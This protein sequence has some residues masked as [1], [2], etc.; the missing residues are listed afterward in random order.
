MG[1]NCACSSP[2]N[3]VEIPQKSDASKPDKPHPLRIPEKKRLP[4]PKKNSSSSV[5][6]K[7]SE[8]S[9]GNDKCHDSAHFNQFDLEMSQNSKSLS[10]TGS[11]Q[12]Q[13]RISEERTVEDR[14]SEKR[15]SDLEPAAEISQEQSVTETLEKEISPTETQEV[16]VPTQA[17]DEPIVKL[18]QFPEPISKV[19]KTMILENAESFLENVE[20]EEI[21]NQDANV[22]E[23]HMEME[24]EP[25]AREKREI[26][27][28]MTSLIVQNDPEQSEVLKQRKQSM[29]EQQKEEVTDLVNSLIVL[30]D[31][32]KSLV[33]K[34]AIL[35]STA[36][37]QI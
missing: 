37:T 32:Q 4:G 23:V 28:L 27:D 22:G 19:G 3:N 2:K 9:Y 13:S 6:A 17:A 8:A 34:N 36:A 11:L 12:I 15:P 14:H 26:S 10:V 18:V 7:I 35:T 31:P 5:Q 33:L 20:R 16:E 21:A 25:E 24:E 29:E 1:N 30:N